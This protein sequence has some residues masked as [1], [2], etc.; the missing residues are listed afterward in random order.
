[1]GEVTHANCPFPG[2][3]NAVSGCESLSS[4]I[5]Q[6]PDVKSSV[7]KMVE[8]A[9]PMSPMHSVISCMLY[10]SMWE[11]LLSSLNDIQ[12]NDTQYKVLICDINV[13]SMTISIT[14]LCHSADLRNLFIVPLSVMLSVVML[15]VVAPYTQP[16]IEGTIG[17]AYKFR[18]PQ[19]HNIKE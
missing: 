8:F 5:C 10:L 16:V 19:F 6:N 7:E 13:V 18:T 3:V 2:I 12:H 1:M 9:L 11:W 14:V 4:F 17:K 15:S